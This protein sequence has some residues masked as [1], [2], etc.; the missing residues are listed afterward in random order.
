MAIFASSISLR[1]IDVFTQN[2]QYEK[3]FKGLVLT[4]AEYNHDFERLRFNLTNYCEQ[5]VTHEGLVRTVG[6]KLEDGSGS[7]SPSPRGREPQTGPPR[8]VEL[9]DGTTELE[10][11]FSMNMT[12]RLARLDTSL[13]E[14]ASGEGGGGTADGEEVLA[15]TSKTGGRLWCALLVEDC[16]PE[17]CRADAEPLAEWQLPTGR[18]SGTTSA[19]RSRSSWSRRLLVN[20]TLATAAEQPVTTQQEPA[21]VRLPN[22]VLS[23]IKAGSPWSN[24]G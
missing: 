21:R 14:L 9:R 5:L 24:G 10:W 8:K 1:T 23:S 22:R 7:S 16:L 13:K 17:F 3:L 15:G 4:E 2:L 6:E 12:S 20:S 11:D 18:I 19:T